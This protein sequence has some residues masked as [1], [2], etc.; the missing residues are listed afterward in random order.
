MGSIINIADYQIRRFAANAPRAP[1]VGRWL[2][3]IGDSVLEPEAA[4]AKLAPIRPLSAPYQAWPMLHR[5]VPGEPDIHPAPTF[6]SA[7]A[8]RAALSDS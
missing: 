3:I 1:L 8:L 7:E 4:K 5:S 2:I 6:A